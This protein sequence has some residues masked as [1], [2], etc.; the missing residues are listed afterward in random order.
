MDII[1]INEISLVSIALMRIQI[2]NHDSCYSVMLPRLINNEGNIRINTEASAV[3]ATSMMI[4]SC[5]I[6]GP[7]MLKSKT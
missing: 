6:N 7:S 3:S 2:N 1:I 5:K 4:A